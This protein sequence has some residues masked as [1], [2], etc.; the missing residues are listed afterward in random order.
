MRKPYDIEAPD[1]KVPDI[2]VP[3]KTNIE[4]PDLIY[5]VGIWKAN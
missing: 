4:V 3:E 1:I 2:E 5:A